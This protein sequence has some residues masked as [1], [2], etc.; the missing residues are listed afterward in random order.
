MLK[1]NTLYFEKQK[2]LTMRADHINS[3]S[4]AKKYPCLKLVFNYN[5]EDSGN[6]TWFSLWLLRDEGSANYHYIGDL[7]IM[8]SEGVVYDMLPNSFCQLDKGFCSVGMDISYY[9]NLMA[10]F[11]RS[12]VKKY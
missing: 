11:K 7:K 1:N 9:K 2:K 5:W 4:P 10:N 3:V 8:S 12:N 6:C